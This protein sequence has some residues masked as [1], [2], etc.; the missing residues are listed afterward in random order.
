MI[1]FKEHSTKTNTIQLLETSSK[2]GKDVH[3]TFK[4]GCSA[5]VESMVASAI[6]MMLDAIKRKDWHEK[7]EEH[8]SRSHNDFLSVAKIAMKSFHFEESVL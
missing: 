4:D 6:V 2:S 5:K 8:I 1:S 7:I 3:I